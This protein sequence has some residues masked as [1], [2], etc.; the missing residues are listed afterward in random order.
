M[1]LPKK[2]KNYTTSWTEL[3]PAKKANVLSML[4]GKTRQRKR[5]IFARGKKGGG[6]GQTFMRT[7]G[8]KS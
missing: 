7:L 5:L 3:T 8:H 1:L 4:T 2:N 6:E